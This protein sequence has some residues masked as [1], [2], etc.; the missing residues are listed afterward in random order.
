LQF[1]FKLSDE[2]QLNEINLLNI[3]KHF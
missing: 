1:K 3:A 2:I